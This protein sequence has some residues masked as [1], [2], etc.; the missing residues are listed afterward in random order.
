MK[1]KMGEGRTEGSR[2]WAGRREGWK[3]E[4]QSSRKKK[5]QEGRRRQ[6]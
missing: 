2:W 5:R 6:G 4:E 1:A 3:A